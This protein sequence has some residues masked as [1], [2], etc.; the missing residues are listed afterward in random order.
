MSSLLEKQYES[1]GEVVAAAKPCLYNLEN[2]KSDSNLKII[3]SHS[4]YNPDL[5]NMDS[6][7]EEAATFSKNLRLSKFDKSRK[8]TENAKGTKNEL[9]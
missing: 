1:D 5:C 8:S 2:S 3:D 9:K 7:F 4:Q 6:S